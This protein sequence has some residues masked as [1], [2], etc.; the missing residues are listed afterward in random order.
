[1]FL[2]PW[3][4]TAGLAA[5]GLPVIIHWLTRPRPVRL[6]LSTLRFVREAVAQR[7]AQYR[8]RDFLVL[9]LRTAAVL[10]LAVAFGRPL[11]QERALISAQDPGKSLRVVILDASQSLAAVSGGAQLFERSR[12]KAG[13]FL[14]YRPD[15]RANLIVLRAMP[16]AVFDQPTDNFSALREELALV[17]PVAERARVQPALNRAAEMLSA[18]GDAGIRREL[19]IISDFQRTNWSTADFSVLPQTSLIQLESVAPS[20]PLPNLAIRKVSSQGRIETGREFR[21][22]VE[23]GNSS[24]TPRNVALQLELGAA[25]NRLSG[26]CPPQSTATLSAD[27]SL[28][29][30]GWQF[31]EA[32]IVDAEDALP[33][34]NRRLFVLDCRPAARFV[35][36]TRQSSK[37]KPSSSFFLERAL[38]PLPSDQD[39]PAESVLRVDATGGSLKDQLLAGDVIVL[40]HPGKLAADTVKLMASLLRRGRGLMYFLAEPI[41][42]ANL[43]L[44]QDMLGSDLQ[45]PVAFAPV[46]SL[47]PRQNLTLAAADTLREPFSI[48]GDEAGALFEPL[49][50]SGG[51]SSRK[52]ETGLADDVRVTYSDGSAALVITACGAG[53]LVLWNV[54]LQQSNLPQSTA[55]VPL[56]GELSGLLLGERRIPG[57]LACGEPF[58]AFL[59]PEAGPSAGLKVVMPSEV[60]ASWET[61]ELIDDPVGVLW[62]EQSAGPPG[63]YQ[64]QRE[65][66]PV[67]AVATAAPSEESELEPL[68]PEVLQGR[69]AGGRTVYYKAADQEVDRHDDSWVWLLTACALALCVE[70]GVLKWFKT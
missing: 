65:G 62:R 58:S 9:L 27:V 25:T 70:C 29:Q 48:F 61:G 17:K 35:L 18:G 51:L 41:D 2:N 21:I 56:L 20:E 33:A 30:M 34:D 6:P 43:Q 39:H 47:Q 32:R 55:F 37:S 5:A 3:A 23:I 7:R 59:S 50:F 26:A 57:A 8:L 22:D 54:D 15:L 11:W 1:M 67:Y 38:A 66:K 53:T 63:I 60:T 19:I 14:S 10:L 42:A 69:L 46:S 36:V 13:E 24:P 49:R 12:A 64:V 68:P 45:L 40:D 4:I 44:L 31:G 52:V 28:G 16:H